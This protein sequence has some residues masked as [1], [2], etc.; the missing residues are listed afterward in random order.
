[1]PQWQR[2]YTISRSVRWYGLKSHAVYFIFL[3]FF[4]SDESPDSQTHHLSRDLQCANSQQYSC[5]KLVHC[6]QTT[7]RSSSPQKL[8]E[9][10]PQL[11]QN[12]HHRHIPEPLSSF[13]PATAEEILKILNRSTAKQCQLDPA[14]TWLIKRV[15]GILA[16]V[17]ANMCNVSFQQGK[18]PISSDCD[19]SSA[20]RYSDCTRLW[21]HSRTHITRPIC[22]IRYG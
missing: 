17:I 15:S 12:P 22:S 7:T 6:T 16:P 1:M 4:C 20:V 14:P 3:Q 9:S 13:E 19:S 2:A 21:R 5:G 8:S 18:V 11:P 10:E